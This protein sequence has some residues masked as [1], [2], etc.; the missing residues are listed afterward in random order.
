MANP[1]IVLP[2][3]MDDEIEERKVHGLP[4]SQYIR[5][6]VMARFNAEDAGEWK[7]PYIPEKRDE[8]QAIPDGKGENGATDDA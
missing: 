7:R 4:K 3:W 6:A 2:D 5:E 1:S 8:S